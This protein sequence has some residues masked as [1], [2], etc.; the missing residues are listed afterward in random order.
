MLDPSITCMLTLVAF[1]MTYVVTGSEIGFGIRFLWCWMLQWNRVSRY[2]W[3]LVRCPPCNS[4]WM[5]LG[6]G[7]LAGGTATAGFQLAFVSCGF[8][9]LIQ[10]LLGGNGIAADE[11][12]MEAFGLEE[13][14]NGEG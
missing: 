3:A 11:N 10:A 8:V 12:F 5:G 9:A 13:D 6:L 14:E 7:I 4:W 2:F 1:G